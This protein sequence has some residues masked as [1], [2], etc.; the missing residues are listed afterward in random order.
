MSHVET[1]IFTDNQDEEVTCELPCVW[2]LFN[3]EVPW[4]LP[5]VTPSSKGQAQEVDK[6]IVKNAAEDS[7]FN[8]FSPAYWISLPWPWSVLLNFILSKECILSTVNEPVKS[9]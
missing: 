5:V 6:D 3:F 1:K 7:L 9:I 4:K 2:S 8:Q